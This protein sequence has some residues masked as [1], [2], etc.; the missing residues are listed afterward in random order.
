MIWN[1]R[2]KGSPVDNRFR[3]T[4]PPR[5]CIVEMNY[6][7]NPWFPPELEEQRRHAQ[8]TMYP[9]ATP[10]FGK[11]TISATAKFRCSADGARSMT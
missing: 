9:G 10:G 6:G 4:T 11:A 7:D 1:P 8:R 2:S 5:S 3:K